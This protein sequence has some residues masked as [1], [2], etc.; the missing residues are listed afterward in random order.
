MP[1]SILSFSHMSS[2]SSGRTPLDWFEITL[3][4][5]LTISIYLKVGIFIDVGFVKIEFTVYEKTWNWE[6]VLLG[7]L[8][9]TPSPFDFVAEKTDTQMLR[10]LKTNLICESKGGSVGEEGERTLG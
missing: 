10:L 7:P 1:F 3:T 4:I 2:L 5:T 9:F 8:V 6:F